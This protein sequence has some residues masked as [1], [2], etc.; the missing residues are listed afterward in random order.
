MKAHCSSYLKLVGVGLLAFSLVGCA[1][2]R[3]YGGSRIPE[4][5]IKD[6]QPGVTTR[7]EILAWFGP[8]QNYLS[9]TLLNQILRE[10]EVT[11]EPL[12]GY[13]F[14]DILSYE[15]TQGNFKLLLLILFNYVEAK[16]KADHLV[17]FFDENERVKYSIVTHLTIFSYSRVQ[18]KDDSLVILFD[19]DG[20]VRSFGFHHGT[21][22][23]TPF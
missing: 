21:A 10:Y 22:E 14:A 1:I 3:Y 23:L 7:Q 9:P 15:F 4:D 18:Q 11:Q 8:P 13:P 20:V 2:G 19:K 17:I 6:I 16:V 5:G 12:T